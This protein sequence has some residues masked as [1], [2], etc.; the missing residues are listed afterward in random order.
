MRYD[1]TGVEAS[2]G[3]PLI[4]EEAWFPFR[5]ITATMGKSKNKDPMVTV[6]TVCLSPKWKDF[7]IRHWV[8]FVP[9]DKPGAGIALH[10][11]KCIGQPYEGVID[12]KPEAWER[13]TFM[14]KVTISDYENKNGEKKKNNKFSSI[15]P[16]SETVGDEPPPEKADSKDAPWD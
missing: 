8:T 10:F 15:S 5:V 3:F 2:E 1:G 9:K 4:T 11:L 16:I 7:P 14:G 13:K 12:I 6:D